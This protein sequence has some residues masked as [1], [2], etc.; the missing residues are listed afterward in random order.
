[1]AQSVYS[2]LLG[3]ASAT[4][5]IEALLDEAGFVTFENFQAVDTLEHKNEQLAFYDIIKTEKIGSVQLITTQ[6]AE[7]E[8]EC[9]FKIR[10]MG[11][12]GDFSDASQLSDSVDE[13]LNYLFSEGQILIKSLIIENV[14]QAARLKRLERDLTLTIRLSVTEGY[15]GN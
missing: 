11:K 15:N 5:K 1:M 6:N 14:K 13:L 12:L 7:T 8:F 9:T 2:T 3:I 4:E 10:L